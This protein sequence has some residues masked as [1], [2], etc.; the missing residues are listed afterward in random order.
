MGINKGVNESH[1]LDAIL[2]ASQEHLGDLVM[3]KMVSSWEKSSLSPKRSKHI[4]QAK[5]LVVMRETVA[6]TRASNTGR[7]FMLLS[8][9]SLSRAKSI[10]E[11]A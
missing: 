2:E 4:I 7:M 1:Y 10:A 11:N 3:E 5:A 8:V 9:K 6:C